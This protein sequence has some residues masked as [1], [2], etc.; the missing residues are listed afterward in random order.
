MKKFIAG[1]SVGLIFGL[2]VS[3]GASG[4]WMRTSQFWSKSDEFQ[5]GYVEGVA[6]TFSM[7][8][9]S[10]R[11]GWFSADGIQ[12]TND[13]FDQLGGTAGPLVTSVK[14]AMGTSKYP[15]DMAVSSIAGTICNTSR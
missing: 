7:L 12:K 4:T 1:V 13:C 8:T 3:A 9:E 5:Y 15:D 11:Q 6:D 2:A 14:S 10:I